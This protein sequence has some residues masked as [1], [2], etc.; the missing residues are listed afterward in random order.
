MA[1][2]FSLIPTIQTDLTG[3]IARP[4]YLDFCVDMGV[5]APGFA[6]DPSGLVRFNLETTKSSK[7]CAVSRAV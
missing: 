1:G 3:L 2:L 6:G 7:I 4:A 5:F